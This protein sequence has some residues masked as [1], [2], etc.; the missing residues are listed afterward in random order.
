MTNTRTG[1]VD[2]A[3]EAGV[4]VTTASDALTGRG[5]VAP[6][7][8]QRVHEVASR[9]G[10]QPNPLARSLVRGRIGL[11]AVAFSHTVDITA[12]MADKDYLRQASPSPGTRWSWSSG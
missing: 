3:A 4:S 2:V 9:L 7:T 10:Y 6:G 12:A 1:L 5:R 8:R 11:I